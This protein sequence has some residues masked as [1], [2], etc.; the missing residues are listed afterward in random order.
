MSHLRS[1]GALFIVSGLLALPGCGTD[2]P[3]NP[4]DGGVQLPDA[5]AASSFIRIHYRL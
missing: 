4:T 2:N 3:Q 5:A 1:F